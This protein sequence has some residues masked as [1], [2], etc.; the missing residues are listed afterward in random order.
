MISQPNRERRTTPVSLLP[1]SD[2][3]GSVAEAA[4]A[5][6]DKSASEQFKLAA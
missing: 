2:T 5:W 1:R 3:L 4:K 6:G